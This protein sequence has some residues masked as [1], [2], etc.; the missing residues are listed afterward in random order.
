MFEGIVYLGNGVE[1]MNLFGCLAF[2]G[3][4]RER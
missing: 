3:Q 2:A 4:L 1:R